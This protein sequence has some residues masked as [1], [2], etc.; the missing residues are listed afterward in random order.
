MSAILGS[1]P[2][3]TSLCL[4]RC[5]IDDDDVLQTVMVLCPLLQEVNLA[6]TN[7]DSD[8]IVPLLSH[9]IASLDLSG[10]RGVDDGTVMSVNACVP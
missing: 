3:L 6:S 5:T 9:R 4:Q 2:Q 1:C 7:V 10:C 8:M